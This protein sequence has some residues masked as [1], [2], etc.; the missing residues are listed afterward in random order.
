MDFQ[1]AVSG[2]EEISI[3]TLEQKLNSEDTIIVFFGRS[4]CPYCRRF[5]PKLAQVAQE[6][7]LQVYFI[8][9]DNLADFEDIQGFRY[10]YG[11]KTVPGLL[12][13]NTESVEVVCDSSLSP[14]EIATFI[15]GGAEK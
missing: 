10:Q 7:A 9:T 8:D 5:T 13:G 4:T 1:E 3:S 12:V 6:N 14:T 15:L 11:I 2:F